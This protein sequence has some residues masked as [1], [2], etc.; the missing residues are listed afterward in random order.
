[1]VRR[2]DGENITS[3]TW[4]WNS[5]QIVGSEGSFWGR[6]IKKEEKEKEMMVDYEFIV[7]TFI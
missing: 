5:I 6:W 3:S 2:I 7:C 4:I 1:M